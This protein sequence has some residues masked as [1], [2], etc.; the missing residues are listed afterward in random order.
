MGIQLT[1]AGALFKYAVEA[2]A[3]VKPTT[4]YTTIPE[5]KEIPSLNPEPATKETTVLSATAYKTYVTGL[6]DLGG[7][8]S[9]K[10][11]LTEEFK[12]I[13]EALMTAYTTAAA[14]GKKVH[15]AVEIPG[16]TQ[17]VF[18]TGEPSALGMPGLGVD[19]VLET[20][21]YITPTGA[22]TWAAKAT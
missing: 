10:A 20:D 14:A 3:G 19:A 2:T 22:P 12:T 11:N 9:F 7:A 6:K 5:M 8:L 15:F 18:F 13:W 4:G 17:A 16:I 1:T 21:V